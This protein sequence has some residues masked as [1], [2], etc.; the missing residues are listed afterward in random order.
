MRLCSGFMVMDALF[1]CYLWSW[2]HC[3]GAIC[4]LQK[5]QKKHLWAC[6]KDAGLILKCDIGPSNLDHFN[7]KGQIITTVV[8]PCL[9]GTSR[10]FAAV[11]SL[12]FAGCVPRNKKLQNIPVFAGF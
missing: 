11:R 4:G 6:S 1:W 7:E 3:F 12:G 10:A 8:R 9:K 5:H 2:T